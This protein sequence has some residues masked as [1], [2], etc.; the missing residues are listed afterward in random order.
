MSNSFAAMKKSKSSYE[1]LAEKLEKTK[2]NKNYTEDERFYYPERD[3]AKNGFA[4]IRFLPAPG[5]E[6]LPWVKRYSHGFK[7]VGGWY[8]EECATTIGEECPV[9]K[10]NSALVNE[11]GSWNDTPAPVK[12]IVRARKRKLQYYANIYVVQDSKNPENEGTVRLFKFGMKIFDKLMS[13]VK[14][15]FEDETPIDP[16]DLWKGA[17]FKLKIRVVDNMTNYD[18]SEFEEASQLLPTDKELEAVW[19]SQYSLTKF[20]DKDQYKEYNELEK[21]RARVV[22]GTVNEDTAEDRTEEAASSGNSAQDKFGGSDN[23]EDSAV[24]ASDETVEASGGEDDTMAYFQGL[25]DQD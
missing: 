14:P 24:E 10:A 18:K 22:G 5:D 12:A 16:F 21:R 2:S 23:T 20:V 7:D 11:H 17:N 15:E 3:K 19:N 9:C 4:I 8:I 13:A 25:A 1:D 6:E